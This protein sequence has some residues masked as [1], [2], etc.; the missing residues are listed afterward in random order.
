MKEIRTESA[1]IV[2]W[3]RRLTIVSLLIFCVLLLILLL[4]LNINIVTLFF[5]IVG[6]GTLIG[7]VAYLFMEACRIRNDYYQHPNQTLNR[8][9]ERSEN[10]K[11]NHEAN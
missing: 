8:D 3:L 6:V 10:Q 7:I 1:E 4:L 11:S 9:E 2:K 5:Y